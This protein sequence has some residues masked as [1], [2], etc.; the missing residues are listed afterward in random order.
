M[1]TIAAALAVCLALTLVLPSRAQA[2]DAVGGSC[3]TPSTGPLDDGT[4]LTCASSIWRY[5]AHGFGDTAAACNSTNAGQVKYSSGALSLCN[6]SAWGAI[7]GMTSSQWSNGS[8]GAIYY[9][10]GNVGIGTTAPTNKLDV[11]G[12]AVIGASYAGTNT[13][14]TNGLLVQGYVGLGQTSASYPLDIK[15]GPSMGAPLALRTTDA[16]ANAQ[17]LFIGNRT[18]Q[19]G[20][21]NASSGFSNLLFFYDGAAAAARMVIDQNGNVGIGTTEPGVKLDVAGAMV[22]RVNNAGSGTSI[23]WSTS[24]TA[25]T[26][27]NCGAFTF[28]NMQDGGTYTLFVQGTTTGTCAFTHSGLTFKYPPGHGATTAAKMTVYAFTRTGSY[29]FVSWTPGY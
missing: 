13:S 4:S 18:Y 15:A 24:N 29:V 6:G 16:G 3:H 11:S 27:A 7:S 1:K 26:S 20:T 5:P 9:N 2:V 28:S 10:A 12:G 19:I 14:P 25:Y 23:D 17:A 21:G 22:S 8:G